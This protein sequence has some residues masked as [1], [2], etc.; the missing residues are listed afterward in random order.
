MQ[1]IFDFLGFTNLEF[2]NNYFLVS[3]K[4]AFF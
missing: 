1:F 4:V 3:K 2:K